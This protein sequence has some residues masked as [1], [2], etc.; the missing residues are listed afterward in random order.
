MQLGQSAWSQLRVL[1][2]HINTLVLIN[3]VAT[4]NCIIVYHM[5]LVF[6][7][8]DVFE[9]SPIMVRSFGGVFFILECKIFHKVTHI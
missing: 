4:W 2:V 1:K 3:V 6:T 9:F 5:L 7:Y 8:M